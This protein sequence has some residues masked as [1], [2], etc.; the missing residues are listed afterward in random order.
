[1]VEHLW[2]V[3]KDP[4]RREPAQQLAPAVVVG[5]GALDECSSGVDVTAVRHPDPLPEPA[6]RV[7]V[8]EVDESTQLDQRLAVII[9]SGQITACELARLENVRPPSISV[10]VGQLEERG[11][12]ARAPDP[13][14]ARKQWIRA[15]KEGRQ[16]FERGHRR[17]LAP[18]ARA[19]A[20]L[21]ARER[22][23]LADCAARVE[24]LTAIIA[25][26]R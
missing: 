7:V 22:A 11:L 15:T 6:L 18:L 14:D 19:I 3:G 2:S 17:R 8:T 5:V 4:G 23:A 12:I 16:V 10:V 1:M 24:T 20:G 25:A 13:A 21:P 26:K 9:H